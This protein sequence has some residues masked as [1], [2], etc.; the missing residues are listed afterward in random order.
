VTRFF[1][2]LV[3]LILQST[4][5]AESMPVPEAL[6]AG[7]TFGNDG[8]QQSQDLSTNQSA[9][10]V[11]NYQGTNVPETQYA[12]NP[13]AI[14][15][16]ARTQLNQNDT[17]A[18]VSESAT[19]R[20]QFQFDKDTDPLFTRSAAIEDNPQSVAGSITGEFSGCQ[21]STIGTP[22]QYAEETCVEWRESQ[23]DTCQETLQLSCNRPIE[24][25]AGGILM[26]SLNSDMQWDYT[27]PTL[28]LGA[29]ADNI[30][31]GYCAVFDRQTTFTIED[32]DKVKEF[33]LVQAGFDD[34]IKIEVN[35]NLVYVGPYGGDR[36]E[37]I[38]SSLFSR[39]QY[40]PSN[41]GGC[42]LGTSWNKT[43]NIDIKPYLQT[44]TNTID[45]RVVVAGGGEGWMKFRATQY[46]DCEW[47]ETWSNDCGALDTQLANGLC[48][49]PT[50]TCLEPT[51]T[52]VIDGIA[53]YRDCW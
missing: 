23:L 26:T 41:Y 3:L 31:S 17:G 36:L 7:K 4:V 14:E 12:N 25:D 5:M 10:T 16:T 53:V 15:D 11:P 48:A 24:C 13:M 50:R 46:C 18:Y 38:T 6:E 47:S 29:N 28:T 35:G 40:G 8:L 39:V 27:Y 43:L 51:E 9:D 20:P 1:L 42:E 49:Q 52:R 2:F 37:V 45:M 30:W 22:P 44:G 19:T 32:I 33:T 21:S 34:W